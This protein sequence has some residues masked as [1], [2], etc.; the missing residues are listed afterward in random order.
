VEAA[1][2]PLG[3][4]AARDQAGALENFEVFGDG[5]EA[6]GEGFGKLGDGEGAEGETGEDG[7]PGGVG[8]SGESGGERVGHV[9]NLLVKYRIGGGLSSIFVSLPQV[10]L[11]VPGGA[12]TLC[13]L[14]E[15]IWFAMLLG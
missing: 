11:A 14:V 3:F 9:F 8:E 2:P 6:H 7:A 5:G 12:N 10:T 15:Q 13:V 4:V 1:R